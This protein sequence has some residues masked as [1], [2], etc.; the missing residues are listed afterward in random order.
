[1]SSIRE[2]AQ[3]HG[4]KPELSI[5]I[6]TYNCREYLGKCLRSV[7]SCLDGVIDYEIVIVDNASADLQ[8]GD[9][10][11]D[12]NRIK[13]LKMSENAGFPRG[14]NIGFKMARGEY[15]LMLNPDTELLDSGILSM[16]ALLKE[17]P[18][19]GI[20]AP[21]TLNRDGTVQATVQDFPTLLSAAASIFNLRR[22][23]H[24]ALQAAGT[25]IVDTVMGSFMLFHSNLLKLAGLLDEN[26]FWIED[27][28]FCYRAFQKGKAVMY[29]PES[30]IVHYGGQS[31][32]KNVNVSLYMQLSNRPRYFMARGRKN[33]ARLLYFMVLVA[34]AFRYA[35]YAGK[36]VLGGDSQRIGVLKRITPRL[37]C[38]TLQSFKGRN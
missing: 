27:I 18:E 7:N 29:Y 28:D 38:D 12:D 13:F 32:G 9:A 16:I 35:L 24:P 8:M 33:E 22:R 34:V 1:M 37:I 20:I 6:V 14:N 21:K 26:L 25:C 11:L 36:Y 4:S 31:A 30:H 23:T 5:V 19:I 17:R 15:V 3:S 10:L 2:V